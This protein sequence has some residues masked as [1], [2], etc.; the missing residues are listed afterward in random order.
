MEVNSEQ[1]YGALLQRAQQR[2]RFPTD[3]DANAPDANVPDANVHDVKSKQLYL[4]DHL[5]IRMFNAGCLDKSCPVCMEQFSDAKIIAV[6]LC[7]HTFHK[8]CIK[9][10]RDSKCPVCRKDLSIV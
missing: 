10:V 9:L 4:P 3:S 2:T 5:T 6:T 7:G 1:L 8:D